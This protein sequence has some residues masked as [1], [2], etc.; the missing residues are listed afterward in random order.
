MAARAVRGRV[1]TV[2]VTLCTL[3]LVALPGHGDPAHAVSPD[4]AP[5]ATLVVTGL[6]PAAVTPESIVTVDVAVTNSTTE[7]IEAPRVDLS[8]VR[9]RMSTRSVLD[10]WYLDDQYLVAPGVVAREDLAPL[11]AGETRSVRLT[12]PAETLGLL[13]YPEAAGPRG[14]VVELVAGGGVLDE[15][16]TFL[17][18]QPQ[19]DPD[20]IT[21]G[22]LAP[23][24]TQAVGTLEARAQGLSAEVTAGGR[25]DALLQATRVERGVTWAVDPAVVEDAAA[26]TAGDAG[27]TWAQTLVAAAEGRDVYALD[28]Y[29]PDVA[30]LAHAGVDAFL[31]TSS[32]TPGSALTGWRQDLT[33]PGPGVVDVPT[34]TAAVRAGRGTVVLS[35]AAPP[36][37]GQP[38]TPALATLAT[39]AGPAT[40]LTPD[41]EL[42]GF[43]QGTVPDVVGS[44]FEARQLLLAELAIVSLEQ[45]GP[46]H[47]LLAAGRDWHPS[48]TD[49][50]ALLDAVAHAPFVELRPLSEWTA[51]AGNPFA[52]D[53]PAEV[54][55]PGEASRRA[56][57]LADEL[58]EEAR[59]VAQVAA[60]PDALLE[61]YLTTLASA[62]SLALRGDDA[63]RTALLESARQQGRAIASGLTVVEGS[64]VNLIAASG[65]LPVTL[66]NDLGQAVTV[67]VMLRPSDPRLSAEPSE[68]VTIEPGTTASVTVPVT[69]IGSGNVDV[70]VQVLADDGTVVAAPAAFTVR[71]RADWES[72]GTAV[73]GVALLVLLV[74]GIA[75]TVRRGRSASRMA[76]MRPEEDAP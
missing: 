43:L 75:R 10:A 15:A 64:T 59:R 5:G 13:T 47:L 30:A 70:D 3:A 11:A 69:A 41:E 6:A 19:P 39:S 68:R 17:L 1:A 8:I 16:R 44:A 66:R 23:V 48:T 58:A 2:L 53:A 54:I 37:P 32:R 22:I 74:A 29:D 56:L 26:G 67:G 52:A 31:T 50:A 72:T 36:E 49:A 61:P 57:R 28:P 21:L 18:W 38:T 63:V 34:L 71:V 12:V 27:I 51:D 20:P 9:Y 25:L 42:S 24:T 76:P 14:L 33:L 35:P 65:D 4:E 55:A 46:E 45:D 7:E 60:E 73:V 40:T 62:S